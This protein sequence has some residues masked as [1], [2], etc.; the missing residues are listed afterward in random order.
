MKYTVAPDVVEHPL[1][2]PVVRGQLTR[3]LGLIFPDV[4]EEMEVA[5]PEV[6]P[7]PTQDGGKCHGGR[8][9]PLRVEPIPCLPEWAAFPVRDTMAAIVSR[10]SN[11]VFVGLPLCKNPTDVAGSFSHV[12]PRP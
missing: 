3:N 8:I 7:L 12:M 5:F 2:I 1:H 10:I 6:M 4:V 11:R 9:H